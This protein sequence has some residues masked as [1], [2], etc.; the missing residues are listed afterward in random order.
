MSAT[1]TA[2]E[3]AEPRLQPLVR[4]RVASMGVRGREWQAGLPRVLAELADAWSLRLG[5][6]VAGGSA[7]YLTSVVRADG[8][9]AVLKVSVVPEQLREEAALLAAADG[10]G[11]VRL[12]E[13]DP[14]RGAV[15]LERLGPSLDAGRSPVDHQLDVLADTLA[16][17]WR[18]PDRPPLGKAR[19]LDGLVRAHW[20]Q[21]GDPCHPV[22]VEQ[23]LAYAAELAAT[24]PGD[25]ALVHGDAHPGNLLRVPQS[26]SGAETG[27]CFV[28]PDPF[29]DDRAYDLGVAVRDFSS[30]LLADPDQASARLWSWCHRVADRTGTDPGRVWAWGFLERVSTGLFV[31]AFGAP[32]VGEPFLRSAELVADQPPR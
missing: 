24:A 9:A 23:A 10:Q 21:L 31:T 4:A 8:T 16:V 5:R 28:D 11:Y 27:W 26:R 1:P 18:P 19:Q 22:V 29:V 25:L 3:Q 2:M 32:R 30:A 7:S 13:A 12:L 20:S 14:G 15:L 6:P 17:A